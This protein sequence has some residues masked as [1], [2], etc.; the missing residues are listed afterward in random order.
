VFP[1]VNPQ[2]ACQTQQFELALRSHT[3]R[4]MLVISATAT[5]PPP[6]I[7]NPF[8]FSVMVIPE[9]AKGFVHSILRMSL[10]K[11]DFVRMDVPQVR[12]VV[13]LSLRIN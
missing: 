5:S 6:E 8:S 7:S 9:P 13:F 3:L 10:L 4:V 2:L 1:C 12:S 11:N